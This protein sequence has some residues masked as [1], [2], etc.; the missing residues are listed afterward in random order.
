[1]KVAVLLS[2]GRHPVSGKPALPRLE[3]QALRIAA[4]LGEATGLHVGPDA[5][6]AEAALGRGLTR[7]VHIESAADLDPVGPIAARLAQ[8]APDVIL[9][10]RRGQGG[11]ETGLVP[12][13]VA[14][15]LGVTLVTDIVSVA[16]GED[17]TLIVDQALPK[18]ALRRLTVKTPV[19]L[20]VH[21]NAL[22]PLPFAF[23]KARRGSV[24][25]VEA[26]AAGVAAAPA[27]AVEERP[28]RKRPRMMRSAPGGGSAADRLKAVTGEASSSGANVLVDPTPEDAAQAILVYLRRIGAIRAPSGDVREIR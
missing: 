16:L 22:S 9:A 11:E 6:A 12:Y 20:T 14:E 2:A 5:F 25:R 1:M 13:A 21:P 7:A 27:A 23:G 3:G 18:G 24:E 26:S 28:Y 4:A 19:L 8:D 10:G 17:G 15:R